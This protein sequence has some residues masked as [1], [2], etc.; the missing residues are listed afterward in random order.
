MIIDH[1]HPNGI[2]GQ[3]EAPVILDIHIDKGRHM[4]DFICRVPAPVLHGMKVVRFTEHI[5]KMLPPGGIVN[6][7][8]DG[9][10]RGIRRIV[11]IIETGRVEA[12]TKISQMGQQTNR[13]VRPTAQTVFNKIR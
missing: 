5:A 7:H 2:I 13:T 3:P 9:L 4:K 12:M 6:F 11:A 1:V 10:N 8:D